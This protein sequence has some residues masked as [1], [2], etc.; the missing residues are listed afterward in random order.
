MGFAQNLGQWPAHDNCVSLQGCCTCAWAPNCRRTCRTG[1]PACSTASP[2]SCSPP[3]AA[4]EAGC[5]PATAL[6][7]LQARMAPPWRRW[8]LQ[9]SE[10]DVVH[11]SAATQ[12]S[13]CGTRSGYCY[14]GRPPQV[15][16]DISIWLFASL[17][18][19]AHVDSSG[20]AIL[21]LPCACMWATQPNGR[22]FLLP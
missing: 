14:G 18:D 16:L 22:R 21:R 12:R 13:S 8:R 10:L 17:S 15:Q 1:C 19:S 6:T 9:I 7:V 3:G 11:C 5:V 2:S 4:I 20:H